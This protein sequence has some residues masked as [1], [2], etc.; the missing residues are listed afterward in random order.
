M[1][2][3]GSGNLIDITTLN[4]D[5]FTTMN[6]TAALAGDVDITDINFLGV[7]STT[8]ANDIITTLNMTATGT[9]SSVIIQGV[10][11]AS[12]STLDTL[13]MTLQIQVW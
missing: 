2:A 7:D 3:S 8:A 6:L 9:G 12:A 1:D 4:V 13:T 10:T 5:H 11:P